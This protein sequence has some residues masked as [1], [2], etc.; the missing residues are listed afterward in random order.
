MRTTLD[1]PDDLYQRVKITAI[2][3]GV[4]LKAFLEEAVVN[5]LAAPPKNVAAAKHPPLPLIRS[6][7]RTPINTTNAEIEE[8]LFGE[9]SR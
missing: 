7:N 4:T 3:R 6:K 8:A 2:Q 1:L 9:L 5:E